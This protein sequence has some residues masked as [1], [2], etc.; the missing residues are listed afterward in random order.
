MDRSAW[1]LLV[2]VVASVNPPRAVA[3]LPLGS[4]GARVR[5]A[6]VGAA[7]TLAV[8]TALGALAT[9]LLDALAV[10]APNARIAAGLVLAVQAVVDLVR[11]AP[12]PEPALPG[13]RA[14][15]VPVAF[16]VLLRPGTGVLAVAGGADHGVLAVLGAATA[17]L[18]LLVALAAVPSLG[19]AT[20]SHEQAAL[21]ER[22]RRGSAAVLAVVLL[23][24]AIDLTVDGILDV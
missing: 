7:V 18:A 1:L 14:G 11:R 3:A 4:V 24:A 21:V 9:P 23:A 22:V 10:S 12:S 20:G 16:P 19:A 6:V 8:L 5:V 13:W 2:L 15:L 17:A